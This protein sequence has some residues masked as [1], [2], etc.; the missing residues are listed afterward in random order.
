MGIEA[1]PN[2]LGGKAYVHLV[3]QAMEDVSTSV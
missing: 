3:A 2:A 1:L